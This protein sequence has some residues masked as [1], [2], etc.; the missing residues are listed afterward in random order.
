MVQEI[1]NRKC[2]LNDE[3]K[4]EKATLTPF[5]WFC[6]RSTDEYSHGAFHPTKREYQIRPHQQVRAFRADRDFYKSLDGGGS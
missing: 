3:E 6:S 4:L 5:T 2:I 1:G